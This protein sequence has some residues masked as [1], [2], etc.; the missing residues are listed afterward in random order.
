M[1]EAAAGEGVLHDGEADQHDDQHEAADQRR[2]DEIVGQ[3]AGHGE[4]GARMTQTQQQEPGRDQHDR[5]V[6][7]MGGEIEHED[8]AD[9][10]D[11]GERNARDA[12]RDRRVIDG[13]ADEGERG[14]PARSPATCEARTCQRLRLR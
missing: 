2:R 8:E 13:K 9:G 1:R 10:G 5:A 12:G 6:V 7:A 11:G 14:R 4:G 3:R